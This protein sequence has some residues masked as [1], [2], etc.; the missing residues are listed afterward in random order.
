MTP[1]KTYKAGYSLISVALM[2]VVIGMGTVSGIVLY[3]NQ[4]EENKFQ[5]NREIQLLVKKSLEDFL[6]KNGRYPCPAPLDAPIDSAA[7]GNE[8]SPT[9]PIGV[10][11]PGTFE[12]STGTVRIGALPTRTMNIDDAAGIDAWG[13]RI[14]YAVS[15]NYAHPGIPVGND[16][17]VTIIDSSGN[18]I[19]DRGIYTIVLPGSDKRGMY[20]ID[21]SPNAQA[22]DLTVPAGENCDFS[23]DIFYA[24]IIEYNNSDTPQQYTATL[25]YVTSHDAYVWSTSAWGPC[26][27]PSQTQTRTVTCVIGGLAQTPAQSLAS[28]TQSGPMPATTQACSTSCPSPPIP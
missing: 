24:S 19:T 17:T 7:W 20:S 6:A 8:V 28:C 4:S 18:I 1:R 15:A 5:K 25:D 11:F 23:N 14:I 27:C 9:C 21:G 26:L 3:K 10:S 13:S 2:L 16:G 12:S 22:C